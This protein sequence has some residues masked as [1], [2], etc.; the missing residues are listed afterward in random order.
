MRRGETVIDEP[1]E[2][3][4]IM[5][6]EAECAQLPSVLSLRRLKLTMYRCLSYEPKT[7]MS[8]ASLYVCCA[9]GPCVKA[10]TYEKQVLFD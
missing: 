3:L 1:T 7:S 10:T 8:V 4:E 6:K 2:I 5:T 9:Q